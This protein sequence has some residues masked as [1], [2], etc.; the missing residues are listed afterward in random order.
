MNVNPNDLVFLADRDDDKNHGKVKQ[1]RPDPMA[2]G[3][4]PYMTRSIHCIFFTTKLNYLLICVPAAMMARSGAWGDGQGAHV[5][6]STHALTRPHASVCP[7]ITH[8]AFHFT[9]LHFAAHSPRRDASTFRP[10][11]SSPSPILFTAAAAAAVLY[12][13]TS[14]SIFSHDCLIIEYLVN[15]ILSHLSPS[16][17]RMC[18]CGALAQVCQ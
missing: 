17:P 14:L 8:P 13:C 18:V 6:P 1:M 2:D 5:H 7:S 9:S 10:S 3:F 15:N 4:G 12:L 16:S 11:R